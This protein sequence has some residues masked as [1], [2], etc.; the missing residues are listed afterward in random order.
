VI[1]AVCLSPAIDV[2]YHVDRLV[3]GTTVRVGTVAERPGGKAVNVARVLH[4]LGEQVLLVAPVGGETGDELRR[5]L[6]RLGLPSRLV[7][8]GT[9]TRRTVTIVDAEGEATCLVEP[10]AMDC[11]PALLATVEES[12]AHARVMVLSGSLPAGVPERGLTSLVGTAHA[13]GVPVV[14]DTHGAALLEALEARC[15]VVKPNADELAQVS[16]GND[17]ARAARGLADRYGTVV[18]ASRGADGIVAATPRGTWEARPAAALAGNPTGAGDALVAGLARGLAHDRTA[19]DHPEETLRA[20]VALSV[21]AVRVPT[22]G[23]V[24]VSAYDDALAGVRVRALDG[25]G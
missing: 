15:D 25:V 16:D 6:A 21:A 10:A 14:A 11:W 22:A 9:C 4:G 17:P 12:L 23:D 8:S 5:G 19:F 20:A 18:V 13:R 24:D 2:T 7:P 1:L 3:H